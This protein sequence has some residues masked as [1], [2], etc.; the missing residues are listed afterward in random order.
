MVMSIFFTNSVKLYASQHIWIFWVTLCLSIGNLV[1]LMFC[2]KSRRKAPHNIIFLMFFT[3]SEG[4][5]LGAATIFFS[6]NEILMG[7]LN[8]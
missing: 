1:G 8:C 5:V 2:G 6:A 4:L 7:K 3:F